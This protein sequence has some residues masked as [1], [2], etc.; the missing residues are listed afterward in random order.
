MQSYFFVAQ[1][2]NLYFKKKKNLHTKI[3]KK[4]TRTKLY[5]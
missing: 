1:I 2:Y 4:F 3:H 5:K